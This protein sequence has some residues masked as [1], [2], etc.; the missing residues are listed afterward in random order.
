MHQEP[1][2]SV[3][4]SGLSC[5]ASVATASAKVPASRMLAPH[6]RHIQSN[7]PV[8]CIP[9]ATLCLLSSCIRVVIRFRKSEVCVV[10]QGSDC[11]HR[12][13]EPEL[14]EQRQVEFIHCAVVVRIN[15]VVLVLR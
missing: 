8:L 2:E 4:V 7:Q 13:V 14:F 9:V 5:L 6:L 15:C 3:A 1:D 11:M 12:D 10:S